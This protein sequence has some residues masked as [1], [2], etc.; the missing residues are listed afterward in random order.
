MQRKFASLHLNSVINIRFSTKLKNLL[1]SETEQ[2]KKNRLLL[3]KN[4]KISTNH[5][6]KIESFTKAL[7]QY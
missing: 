2:F 1:N 4:T 3:R 7:V 5:Y 6:I